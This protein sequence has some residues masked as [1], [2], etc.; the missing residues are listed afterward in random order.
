MIKVKGSMLMYDYL[1]SK[2][3]KLIR[4]NMKR[5]GSIHGLT[6]KDMYDLCYE[7]SK[8]C[9]FSL[10]SQLMTYD[11]SDVKEAQHIEGLKIFMLCQYHAMQ[12]NLQTVLPDGF[13]ITN[14]VFFN[15]DVEKLNRQKALPLKNID[16]INQ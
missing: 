4:A 9:K 14:F 6:R 2:G 8:E 11:F 7:S 1:E 10:C 3:V 15:E 12:L 16:V 13:N 5:R